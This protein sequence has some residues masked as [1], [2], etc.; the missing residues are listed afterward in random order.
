MKRFYFDYAAATPLDPDAVR[1][2]HAAEAQVGNPSSLHAEGRA[3]RELL[4]AA[5]KDIAKILNARDTEIVFTSTATEANN[6]AI[7]G[8][9]TASGDESAEILVAATEHAAV[10]RVTDVIRASG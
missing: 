6:L 5:R 3:M 9:V 2:M 8:A 4:S 1:A 10:R 7:F